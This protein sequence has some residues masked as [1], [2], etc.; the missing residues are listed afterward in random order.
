MAKRKWPPWVQALRIIFWS[1]LAL[2]AV[3]CWIH[4]IRMPGE[5]FHGTPP[6]LMPNEQRLREELIARVHKLGSEIGERNIRRYGQ[7]KAAESYIES[8]FQRAGWKVRRDEY[9]VA[10]RTCA[11]IEAELPGKT[12][13]IVLVGAHYDSV[14]GAPGANDNGSGVAAVLALARRFNASPNARTL[15]FVAFVNEEPDF[16]QTNQMGSYVYAKRCHERGD[17]IKVMISLE[18]IG[19]FTDAPGSQRYPMFLFNL[20]YPRTGNFIGFVGNTA[21]RELVREAI[22][23]FRTHAQIPS[24]GAAVPEM[25]KGV[26]WSDQWSFWQFGYPAIMVTDTAPFRY[27]HYHRATDTPDKLNYEAM[28]R[29]VSGME[30]VIAHLAN[31]P[32]G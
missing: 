4:M 22:S 32:R 2:L 30:A 28:T 12:P 6:P 19:Y 21:S 17:Q 16:F 26:G 13:D 8:Q 1:S 5:N 15:R 14:L 24:E 9:E 11:N 3:F 18:T 29:V 20:L 7:L 27:P 25:V 23:V 10:G 31:P